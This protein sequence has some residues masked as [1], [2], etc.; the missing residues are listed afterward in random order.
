MIIIQATKQMTIARGPMVLVLQLKRF[1]YGNSGGKISKQI[2]FPIQLTIPLTDDTR[3]SQAKYELCGVVVHHGTSVHS[4]HYIAYVKSPCGQWCE[5]NDCNV[6]IVSVQ[7]VLGVQAY[8][9]F[10]T[11]SDITPILPIPSSLPSPISSPL[12]HTL[13]TT[14][15]NSVHTL[16]VSHTS[17]CTTST[18]N[19]SSLMKSKVGEISIVTEIHPVKR[20]QYDDCARLP[21]ILSLFLQPMRFRGAVFWTWRNKRGSLRLYKSSEKC[22]KSINYHE[23]DHEKDIENDHGCSGKEEGKKEVNLKVEDGSHVHDTP[24]LSNTMTRLLLNMSK[25][26]R[27]VDGEGVWEGVSAKVFSERSRVV[28]GRA[29]RKDQ[30]QKVWHRELDQGRLKKVN[31][32]KDDSALFSEQKNVFQ[33]VHNNN[34]HKKAYM[35]SW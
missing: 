32:K 7:Y 31:G 12:S 22:V 33:E 35:P 10:Y 21:R 34:G 29:T 14:H 20:L 2:S 18:L 16:N 3:T 30:Q 6:S 13:H 24:E 28:N 9:L 19:T 1:S 26:S 8:M 23:N 25:R 4:G 5:M 27:D 15:A 17:P 11:R